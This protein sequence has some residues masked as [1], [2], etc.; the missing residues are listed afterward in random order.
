MNRQLKFPS[1]VK[2]LE[3]KRGQIGFFDKALGH[4]DFY[5]RYPGDRV[6]SLVI[7]TIQSSNM[8]EK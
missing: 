2:D 8:H 3:E 4:N 5:T 6:V 7:A 1:P